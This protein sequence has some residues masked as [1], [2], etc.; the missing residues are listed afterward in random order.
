[1]KVTPQLQQL[2]AKAVQ[3]S[4]RIEGYAAKASPEVQARAAELM[5]QHRVQVSVPSK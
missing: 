1:M 4:M 5:K 3:T 2:M